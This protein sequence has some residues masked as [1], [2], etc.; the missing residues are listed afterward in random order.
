MGGGGDRVLKRLFVKYNKIKCESTLSTESQHLFKYSSAMPWSTRAGK[1][2]QSNLVFHFFFFIFF[3][4]LTRG[5][6]PLQH[7]SST[8]GPPS[9]QWQQQHMLFQCEGRCSGKTTQAVAAIHREHRVVNQ[10]KKNITYL[11][12]MEEV[13]RLS[14]TSSLTTLG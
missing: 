8:H 3:F 4:K 2:A 11:C 12:T 6:S 13:S 14:P 9:Q 7:S 10:F 5:S 1:R